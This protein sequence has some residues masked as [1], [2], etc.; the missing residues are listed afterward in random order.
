MS[1]KEI[2]V[3]NKKAYLIRVQIRS[4]VFSHL[5]VQKQITVKGKNVS[6]N[7]AKQK[8]RELQI[9]CYEALKKKEGNDISFKDAL[10][11]WYEYK[12]REGTA[13]TET[14]NDYYSALIKWSFTIHNVPCNE[15]NTSDIK[16]ILRYQKNEGISRSFRRKYKSMVNNVFKWAIEEGYLHHTNKSP[17]IGIKL[18]RVEEKK[19]EI[20]TLKQTRELLNAAKTLEHPWYPV[21]A[22]AVLTGARNGELYALEKSDIDLENNRIIIS[23]SFNNRRGETKSTKAGYY[24]SIPINCELKKLILELYNQFPESNYV[25][26]RLPGWRK[27]RQAIILRRF[28]VGIGLPSVKFHTLRA[29]FATLLLQ[30][31]IAPAIIMKV[32]GWQDLKTMERYVRLAGVDEQGVTD[33]L[34]LLPI[35]QISSVISLRSV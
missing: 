8:E 15:I 35:D 27:G 31:N 13:T 21:W 9:I 29:C 32:C 14:I 30:Q 22:F 34:K 19:P 26:P 2:T 16:A 28:L 18:E 4:K 24:R 33:N 25:L 12:Y 5:R 23:K 3:N 7:K 1:I 11:K 10:N 20:L 17:A 6:L